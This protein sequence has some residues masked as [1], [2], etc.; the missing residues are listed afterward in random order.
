M[1]EAEA[2]AASARLPGHV[3]PFIHVA[4]GGEDAGE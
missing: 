3:R 4:M 2:L 1:T